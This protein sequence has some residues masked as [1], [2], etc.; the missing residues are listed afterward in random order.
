MFCASFHNTVIYAIRNLSFL[1]ISPAW[2][3]PLFGCSRPVFY[4]F[5]SYPKQ[6]KAVSSSRRLRRLHISVTENLSF[7]SISPGWRPPLF[8]CSRQVIYQSHSYPTQLEAVSSSR[9]LRRLHI[10]VI[11]NL[12][13]LSISP[14]WRPPLFGCSR[15]VI[16]QSHSYPTQLEAVSS[17]RR[18]RR[19]HI[20]VTE[21]G[22]ASGRDRLGSRE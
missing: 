17:S 3:P 6:L 14:A 9:R 8:G 20:S 19:L 7:L 1:S 12:S 4:Q 22:R 2:R 5:H 16:Y 18:L 21:N 15:P 11:E 13:F 10:L